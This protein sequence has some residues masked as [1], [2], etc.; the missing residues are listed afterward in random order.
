MESSIKKRSVVIGDRKTSI[1]LEDA[2]WRGAQV[3]AKRRDI[4][5]FALIN[6]IEA[7]RGGGNLSSAIRVYIVEAFMQAA[8]QP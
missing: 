8:D 4:T 7:E 6:E 3:L 1:S 5:R 2:F